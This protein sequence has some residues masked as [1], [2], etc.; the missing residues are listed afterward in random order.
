MA[1]PLRNPQQTLKNPQKRMKVS[2][3]TF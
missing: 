2:A 3:E 1:T